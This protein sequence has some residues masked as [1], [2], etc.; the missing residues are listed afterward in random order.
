MW[1][2]H[3]TLGHRVL[4]SFLQ[5]NLLLGLTRSIL[6]VI[7]VG[8]EQRPLHLWIPQTGWEQWRLFLSD[9]DRKIMLAIDL[10]KEG[11]EQPQTAHSQRSGACY[12]HARHSKD[13]NV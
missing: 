3:V 9:T 7:L 2:H 11:D 4:A 1:C 13:E 10:W 8:W 12:K 6:D 5:M